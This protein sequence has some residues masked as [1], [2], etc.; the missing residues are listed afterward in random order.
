MSDTKKRLWWAIDEGDVSVV[1]EVLRCSPELVNVT[2]AHGFTVL[3]QAVTQ[4]NRT[5]GMIEAILA[6][7]ADVN[8][9]TFEGY[10]ALH[11]A[12]DVDAGARLNAAEVIGLLVSAGADLKLRQHYGWTPLLEAVVEGRLPE[13]QALLDAG[14]DPNDT[15]PTHTLPR[16]NAGR[17]T[18][19]AAITNSLEVVDALL[20][21]GA[22]PRRRDTAGMDFFEYAAYVQ[23]ESGPGPFSDKVAACARVARDRERTG[24]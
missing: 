1:R 8:R 2:D 18:L 17:T 9:Q 14:A 19:M 20:R 11:C 10:T 13:V 16:F 23:K 5:V 12:I 24:A 6:A 4:M 15:L 7:G 22:D 3:M 21:A